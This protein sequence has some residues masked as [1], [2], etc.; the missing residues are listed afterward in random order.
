ME[1]IGFSSGT[2][3]KIDYR[4]HQLIRMSQVSFAFFCDFF[5]LSVVFKNNCYVVLLLLRYAK[6]IGIS[7]KCLLDQRGHLNRN[8]RLWKTFKKIP[9][10][11]MNASA[12]HLPAPV[13]LICFCPYIPGQDFA[14]VQQVGIR[15]FCWAK[16][17]TS[18]NPLLL[19]RL[20]G[21]FLL[22]SAERQ[23]LALLFQLPP[24]ITRLSP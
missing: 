5:D 21:V 20:P 12:S 19:F 6:F 3:M 10:P 7:K 24:R 17:A 16:G 23:F 9:E 1:R 2:V 15:L 4:N 13:F 14:D 8:L 11:S 18:R 22:R